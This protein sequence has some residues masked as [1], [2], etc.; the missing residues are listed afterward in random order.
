MLT[1][2]AN[3]MPNTRQK[4]KPNKIGDKRRP[5]GQFGEGNV[6]N[7]NGRPKGSLSLVAMLKAELEKAPAGQTKGEKKTWAELLIRRML[8]DSVIEG[9]DTL[10]RDI[11]DRV[12]GKP[13]INANVN[14]THKFAGW[15]KEEITEYVIGRLSGDSA[16]D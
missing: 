13:N 14:T 3:V 15:S 4:A 7:P 16:S 5:N 9:N 11:L 1:L 10:I 2:Y 12:D 8:K 6:A